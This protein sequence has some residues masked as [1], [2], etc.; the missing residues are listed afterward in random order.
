MQ[1]WYHPGWIILSIWKLFQGWVLSWLCLS[2]SGGCWYHAMVL[3]WW[4]EAVKCVSQE[5]QVCPCRQIRG[6]RQWPVGHL[7]L[8]CI[9]LYCIALQC[10]TFGTSLAHWITWQYITLETMVD[11]AHYIASQNIVLYYILNNGQ[12]STL[13][14]LLVGRLSSQILCLRTRLCHKS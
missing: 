8:H 13:L 7:T 9:A 14:R 12:L 6:L 11:W 3:P 10:I 2:F 4:S 1:T 5:N